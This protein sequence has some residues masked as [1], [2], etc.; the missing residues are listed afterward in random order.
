MRFSRWHYRGLPENERN[1][2]QHIVDAVAMSFMESPHAFGKVQLGEPPA[3]EGSIDPS[4]HPPVQ[5][6]HCRRGKLFAMIP[7]NNDE[8]IVAKPGNQPSQIVVDAGKGA[9]VWRAA[10]PST[11]TLLD[12]H[13]GGMQRPDVQEH[14]PRRLV[15][16]IKPF[17]KLLPPFCV[18]GAGRLPIDIVL[19]ELGESHLFY[20]RACHLGIGM[21]AGF[22][23][24]LG[25][26]HDPCLGRVP[27]EASRPVLKGIQAREQAG[28]RRGGRTS[29]R[30]RVKKGESFGLQTRQG[31]N[32][33]LALLVDVVSP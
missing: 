17:Q 16:A 21:V 6:I 31:R 19:K 13:P 25:E 23:E 4:P 20:Q 29:H 2:D 22:A 28:K 30:D 1:L 18:D 14:K 3:A 24:D 7:R 9:C 15:V 33:G 26:S 8:G 12:H 27:R 5:R 32:V 11:A 10:K